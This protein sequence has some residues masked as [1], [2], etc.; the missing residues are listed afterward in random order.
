MEILHRVAA[1]AACRVYHVQKQPGTL[2]VAQEIMPQ[3][4]AFAGAFH[5]TGNIR[6]HEVR[7]APFG[8]A[9][10]GGQG[11][12]VIVG[13]L[14]FRRRQRGQN[15]AFAHVGEADQPHVRNGFQFQTE[16]MDLRLDARL[17]KVGRLPG[18]RGKMLVAVP[19]DTAPKQHLFLL[20]LVHVGGHGAVLPQKDGAHG[21]FDQKILAPFA[22]AAVGAAVAAAFRRVLAVKAEVQQGMHVGVGVQ[23]DIA[24]VAAV[25]AV[26]A[27]VHDEFF[28]VERHAAVSAVA[29]FRGNG[30]A[31]HK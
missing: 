1:L 12:K 24:A 9:Q 26:R 16:G 6:Q 3:S 10:I 15:G 29:R 2:H 19:A 20:R 21:H 11:G 28:P 17:G 31:I 14:G 7:L 5:Q 25:A 27:P 22:V 13:D 30:N 23:D 8:N 18:R 4:H